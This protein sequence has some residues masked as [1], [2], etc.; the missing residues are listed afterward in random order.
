MSKID[1]QNR[2]N[3]CSVCGSCEPCGCDICDCEPEN[4]CPNCG[5]CQP[6]SCSPTRGVSMADIM[7][8]VNDLHSLTKEQ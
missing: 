5:S 6:C 1:I 4:C 2:L 8:A 3:S 7:K